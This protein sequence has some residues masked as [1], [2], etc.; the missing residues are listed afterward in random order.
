MKKA[1]TVQANTVEEAI[2]QALDLIGLPL[3]QVHVEVISNPGRRLM[4]F[5]KVM[6]EVT[7]T[8]IE[9]EVPKDESF[10]ELAAIVDDVLFTDF[11]ADNKVSKEVGQTAST[12]S[13]VKL[14]A[15]ELQFSFDGT[16]YPVI[17]PGNSVQFHVNGEQK[18]ERTVI[19]PTDE[20]TV[21]LCDEFIPPQ[22]SIQLIEQEMIALL[23]FTPGKRVRRTLVDTDWL[24]QLHL[25]AEEEVEYYNNLKPQAIVD[26]LKEM[27]IQ[28]GLLFPAIKKVTEVNKPYELI[29]AK[30]TLPVEGTDGDLEVHIQ[31]EEFD[32][33]S[34]EKVDFREMNAIMNVREGQ[35]IA[36]HI[37][38]VPGTEG[39]N[40]LGKPIRVKP[41]RDIHLKLG[42]NVKQVDQDIVAL[43]SGK[44][45]LDWRDKLVRIDVHHEF[46]HPGEV[47]MESGNIRFE[48]D[49]RIGGNVMPSMFVGA[50]GAIYIGGAVTK[51]TVH[52]VQSATIRGNVLS[53]TISVG[54]QEV[55]I[56]ELVGYLKSVVTEMEQIKTA[57]HQVVVIR[58]NDEEEMSPSELKRLIYLLMEKKYSR[59]EE[60]NKRFIQNV[61]EY[62]AQLTDEWTGIADRLYDAFIN[63]LKESL[64]GLAEFGLLIEDA[65]T[66]I[67]IYGADASP[68][69]KLV[70][71]YAI[72]STLFSNGNI[73]VTS[74]GVYHSTLTAKH[75]ITIKGVCRGGEII[76]E[77]L[78]ALQETGSENPVKTVVKTSRTGRIKI[79]LAYAG[80]EIQVG[81]RKHVFSKNGHSIVAR[82]NEEDELVLY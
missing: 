52:A 77:N 13:G 42:K 60:L 27:G 68:Q 19:L 40:L 32:P 4:G 51:A 6:A 29:V 76:A 3:E 53:S 12:S 21:T 23:Q 65:K 64:E 39:R 71:P 20:V 37:L 79:G 2:Q 24:P 1:V 25:E 61:K 67:D 58:G 15:G 14:T 17:I 72:N 35:V 55:V 10:A 69:N 75:D 48:G 70:L 5:R 18:W 7:V 66:L 54:E 30:G 63:P 34:E 46:N 56:S 59:F 74:K 82:L 73:E 80:T 38:P 36:T 62:A 50:T 45:S 9:A 44:P 28:Q 31:Y 47:D 33:D 22:F 8:E 78:I 57:I 11:P 43:I 49:V 26:V 41:V 16:Q 81:P